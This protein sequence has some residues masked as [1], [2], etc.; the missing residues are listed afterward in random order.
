MLRP[1]LTEIE[2]DYC[3]DCDGLTPATDEIVTDTYVIDGETHLF[4]EKVCAQHKRAWESQ[5]HSD[6]L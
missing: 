4:A 6:W 3:V 2:I 5:D 1:E